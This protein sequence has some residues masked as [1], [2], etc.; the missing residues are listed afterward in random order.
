MT[1]PTPQIPANA[2]TTDETAEQAHDRR[3]ASADST[4]EEL[5]AFRRYSSEVC[6]GLN[7]DGVDWECPEDSVGLESTDAGKA[8]GAAIVD[9]VLAEFPD[10]PTCQ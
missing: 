3:L 2:R 5:Q 8:A 7:A 1:L 6:A 9:Q 10:L 4:G